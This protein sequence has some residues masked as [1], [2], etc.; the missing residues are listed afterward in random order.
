MALDRILVA[1]VSRAAVRANVDPLHHRCLMSPASLTTAHHLS[2]Y[3]LSGEARRR[4]ET[5]GTLERLDSSARQG[6]RGARYGPRLRRMQAPNFHQVMLVD[7]I[8]VEIPGDWRT[9]LSDPYT[10]AALEELI[11]THGVPARITDRF[12]ERG[13]RAL[14][15]RV[16]IEPWNSAFRPR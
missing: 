15:W 8:Y 10:R 7:G 9:R 14:G 2:S 13:R 4:S 12:D 16:P 1:Q 6:R 11:A 3:R 5:N